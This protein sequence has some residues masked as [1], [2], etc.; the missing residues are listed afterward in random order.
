MPNDLKNK[1]NLKDEKRKKSTKAIVEAAQSIFVERGFAGTSMS[2]IAQKAQVPQALI[3][4]YFSSKEELW[5][6]V[7]KAGLESSAQSADFGGGQ[8]NNFEEFLRI[9]LKNRTDFYLKNPHLRKLIQWES[10]ED[11]TRENLLGVNKTYEGIWTKDLERL[12]NLEKLP[13]SIDARLLS[14]LIRNA[15]TAVFEDIPYL[16][17]AQKVA[18]K[19]KEYLALLYKTLVATTKI[20]T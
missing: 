18:K 10:L 20:G 16:Y 5:K 7:K 17:P 19:Q 13:S 4:H 15:I 2:Q 11:T 1:I 14:A 12:Q 3:Y 8:A 9:V 6:A